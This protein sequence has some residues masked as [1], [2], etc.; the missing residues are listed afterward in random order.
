MY[1]YL[2]SEIV[3]SKQ[4]TKCAF[5]FGGDSPQ[6]GVPGGIEHKVWDP[7]CESAETSHPTSRERH[8]SAPYLR[9]QNSKR[10]SKCQS[11]LFYSTRKTQKLDRIGAQGGTLGIF[12][13]F[14]D[15]TSKN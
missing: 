4:R 8:K 13:P 11:I 1:Y 7:S 10:T 5:V 9:L 14:F 2:I 12:Y 3:S 6:Q 15:E